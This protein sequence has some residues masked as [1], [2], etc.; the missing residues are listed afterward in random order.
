MKRSSV[1][2]ISALLASS[3]LVVNCQK[4][5]QKKGVRPSTPT[6]SAQT[7]T[8]AGATAHGA[9]EAAKT[10]AVIP[11]N[12]CN[13][14][15]LTTYQ[16]MVNQAKYLKEQA[17]AANKDTQK[18]TETRQDVLANCDKILTVLNKEKDGACLK[19]QSA[20]TEE[21]SIYASKIKGNL[22]LYV[23]QALATEN[24]VDNEYAKEFQQ[25]QKA[26]VAKTEVDNFLES[27]L[28][29]SKQAE[30][31]IKIQNV[32]WNTFLVGG[33]VK[34]GAE[35]LKSSLAAKAMVCSFVDFHLNR[36]DSNEVVLKVINKSVETDLEK[37]PKNYSG[38]N[39]IFTVERVNQDETADKGN[40][41]KLTCI[42]TSDKEL[43]LEK[44]KTTFG[45]H[46]VAKTVSATADKN[47]NIEQEENEDTA[48]DSND[49][50]NED[51]SA[52]VTTNTVIVSGTVTASGTGTVSGAT[53]TSSTNT[54]KPVSPSVVVKPT[55]SSTV[56]VVTTE[57]KVTVSAVV[58]AS[59]GVSTKV[60]QGVSATTDKV[61]LASKA[62]TSLV[63]SAKITAANAYEK[64][65]DMLS[66]A[67]DK[68]ANLLSGDDEAKASKQEVTPAKTEQ[69][70][71][72]QNIS[73][74]DSI[75]L[76]AQHLYASAVNSL[77]AKLTVSGSA[78]VSGGA[79]VSG[80]AVTTA[81]K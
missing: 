80:A 6:Q 78:T 40:L 45:S 49:E 53:P 15:V 72:T 48:N 59:T 42:N 56:S 77:N 52:Q 61:E 50:Q 39:V 24:K 74:T 9:N 31:M 63:D 44:I 16:E 46:I 28:V 60:S 51:D 54:A 69:A 35:V 47:D 3:M 71:N 1:K 36:D 62:E 11:Q 21:N 65:R 55:A 43:T 68:L 2:M 33:E 8:A 12:I 79:T 67:Y 23:G 10:T 70:E 5:P 4:A 19:D 41:L 38:G 18:I 27:S 76:Q 57:A 25:V 17:A 26:T 37:L 34:H 73:S 32:S 81:Q 64:M 20:K 22:C 66:S 7:T 13:T 75:R 58:P 29:L 14:E 30:E